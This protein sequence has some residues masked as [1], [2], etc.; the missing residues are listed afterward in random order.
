MKVYEGE[1]R[2]DK[3]GNYPL[4]F[5][6]YKSI[7]EVHDWLYH[8]YNGYHFVIILDE[9]KDEYE[10]LDKDLLVYF[11]DTVIEEL[12]YMCDYKLVRR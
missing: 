2:P 3:Y 9:T 12:A 8:H 4:R 1:N 5:S 11:T 6:G 10:P 7:K